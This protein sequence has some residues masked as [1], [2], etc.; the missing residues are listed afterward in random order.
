MK[1]YASDGA[2]YYDTIASWWCNIHG[3]C[4]KEISDAIAK[5]AATLDHTLFAGITHEPA[6]LLAKKLTD[7]APD[8]LNRVFYSDNGSCSVE[9]ALKMSTRV[10][11]EPWKNE[12]APLCLL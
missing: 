3:H 4:R 6:V 9:I 7:I 8:G 12:Q 10:P 5:Q 11:A 2:F 1:L